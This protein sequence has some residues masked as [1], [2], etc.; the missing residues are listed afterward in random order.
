[1]DCSWNCIKRK[2]A[3][4]SNKFRYDP[5][6]TKQF[7]GLGAANFCLKI[8]SG[9]GYWLC[10]HGLTNL[11]GISHHQWKRHQNSFNKDGEGPI[12]HQGCGNQNRITQKNK[13]CRKGIEIYLNQLA[14]QQGEPYA[15][16]FIPEVT[17]IGIRNEENGTILLPS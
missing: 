15:T 8:E 1:M 13:D 2:V 16:R 14:E 3:A 9:G 17:G 12:P 7:S 6:L 4:K 10:K 5:E 11:L